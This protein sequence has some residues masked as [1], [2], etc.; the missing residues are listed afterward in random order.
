MLEIVFAAVAVVLGLSSYAF[1]TG[2][3]APAEGFSPQL[4]TLLLLANLLPLLALM[5]LIAR[6]VAILIANRRAGRAGAQ[7][8][9]RL[10]ALFAALAAAPTILVVIFASLLFQFGV[11]FWFSDRAKTVLDNADRV[12][13]AYV[14]ENKSRILADIVAMGGD[15]SNYSAQFGIGTQAFREGLA[16]QVAGR[17]LSEA[18]VFRPGLNGPVIVA[19]ENLDSPPLSVR[20]AAI[21]LDGIRPGEALVVASARDKIEAIVRLNTQQPLFVYTSRK[22][23][24]RVL[25]QVART[26]TALTDYKALTDRSRALQW[27]FNLILLVVSLLVVAAA[28]WFAILLASRIV[29]P[30]ASWPKPPA[31]WGRAIWTRA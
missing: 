15:L 24:P 29:S 20:T 31:G 8:H 7:L 23:E 13:Q 26:Q 12:A 1:L 28:V 11:Q 21:N 18:A 30:S 27:R 25:E 19:S 3:R 22:V 16:F 14:E 10:V 9:V 5:L 2:Q 17:N 6:R 4:V